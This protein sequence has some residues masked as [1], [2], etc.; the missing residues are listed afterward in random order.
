MVAG[1]LRMIGPPV[2]FLP[3]V[4]WAYRVQRPQHLARWRAPL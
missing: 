1:G 3:I 2:V 4:D